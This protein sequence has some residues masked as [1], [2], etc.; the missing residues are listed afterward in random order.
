MR[1]N[2]TGFLSLAIVLISLFLPWWSM[3]YSGVIRYN[4]AIGETKNFYT[5]FKI[6]YSAFLGNAMFLGVYENLTH[7]SLNWTLYSTPNQFYWDISQPL[8]LLTLTS[9]FSILAF[10]LGAIGCIAIGS[11]SNAGKKMFLIMGLVFACSVLFQLGYDAHAG[12]TNLLDYRVA[13]LVY[14][15][16]IF[17]TKQIIVEDNV[18]VISTYPN[19]GFYL[20]IAGVISAFIAWRYPR[21]LHLA[22]DESKAYTTKWTRWLEVSE[23][24]KLATLFLSS[25]LMSYLLV[26][27]SV[28]VF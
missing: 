3:A 10:S 1:L 20:A 27:L 12:I 8:Y 17:G 6:D 15:T 4:D 21:W 25:L 28:F 2:L 23:R 16:G 7:S 18:G 5:A 11:W 22:R 14:D 26:F 13:P 24:E 9:I 19:I